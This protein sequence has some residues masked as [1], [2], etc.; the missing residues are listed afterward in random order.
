MGV[1][2]V[3][4]GDAFEYEIMWKHQHCNCG[5]EFEVGSTYRHRDNAPL[6]AYGYSPHSEK[7][8]NMSDVVYRKWYKRRWPLDD[9]QGK[10]IDKFVMSA[11]ATPGTTVTAFFRYIRISRGNEVR[12]VVFDEGSE[13]PSFIAY[14]PGSI[15]T[16]CQAQLFLEITNANDQ[17]ILPVGKILTIRGELR[18]RELSD[19][20][21]SRSGVTSW[22]NPLQEFHRFA[23]QRDDS[24]DVFRINLRVR[25]SEYPS[26]ILISIANITYALPCKPPLTFAIP[27]HVPEESPLTHLLHG[28]VL[29][30]LVQYRVRGITTSTE[31]ILATSIIQLQ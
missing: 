13:P 30:W 16:S 24:I 20:R 26:L 17:V 12:K 4:V 11:F 14:F 18:S 23:L 27:F 31:S 29:E 10:Y 28:G 5:A 9:I 22:M 8:A 15:V 21:E 3:G 19:M 2:L 6:D 1:L 25:H 7:N